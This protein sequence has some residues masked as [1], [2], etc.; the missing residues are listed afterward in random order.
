MISYMF[1]GSRKA[2]LST[3]MTYLSTGR[4]QPGDPAWTHLE[5]VPY[6]GFC[7]E[8]GAPHLT[9]GA[10]RSGEEVS[11]DQESRWVFR[12]PRL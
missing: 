4:V 1:F 12:F 2:G 6:S 9:P 5:G 7:H 3:Q 8:F 11:R 10:R